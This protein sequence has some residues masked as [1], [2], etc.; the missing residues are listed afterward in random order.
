M[1]DGPDDGAGDPGARGGSDATDGGT[2]ADATAD[3]DLAARVADLER[4]VETL[5]ET[6][7]TLHETVERQRR[8]ISYL[9]AAAGTES[10]EPVC[11]DCGEGVLQT[12]S[13]LT[14]RQV[15][16]PECELKQYL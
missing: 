16:C 2:T 12:S 8:D 5:R 14:W 9:A 1:T 4:T 13:G 11:P 7:K 10:V 15:S 3:G 6:V